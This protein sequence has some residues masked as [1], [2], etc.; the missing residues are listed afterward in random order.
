MAHVDYSRVAGLYKHIE[1]F[2]FGA[3]L[4]VARVG[5]LDDL[6]GQISDSPNPRVLVVGDGDGRFLEEFLKR[7][8][9]C[10]VDY[11][12]CSE[13]MLREAQSR[14]G[15][16]QQVSWN[17][18]DLR[19]W[20][21]SDYDAVVAHFFLDG[22]EGAERDLV[23]KLLV[24]KL[25]SKGCVLLSDFDPDTRSWGALFVKV[26]QFF[27][28]PVAGLPFVKVTRDDAAFEGLGGIKVSERVWQKG[29]IYAQL[30]KM[31]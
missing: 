27:F 28:R 22:F 21:G 26:M 20:Q 18:E 9:N 11:V 6:L 5:L 4:Q 10:V 24:S 12:D 2:V 31:Y 30:W 8:F 23:V 29:W 13:G 19:R 25:R 7:S 15:V 1:K 17:C 16:D 3:R 14:V